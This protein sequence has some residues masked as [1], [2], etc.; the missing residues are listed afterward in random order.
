MK[1]L[2][3]TLVMGNRAMADWNPNK[4]LSKASNGGMGS[5]SEGNL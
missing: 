4:P 3:V 2:F 5:F 1:G